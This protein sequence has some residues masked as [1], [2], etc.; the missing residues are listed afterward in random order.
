MSVLVGKNARAKVLTA[1]TGAFASVL[2]CPLMAFGATPEG[3]AAYDKAPVILIVTAAIAVAV[4]L[5]YEGVHRR[6]KRREEDEKEA[7]R[8]ARAARSQDSRARKNN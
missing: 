3:S 4:A 2:C 1:T 5:I 7:A 6:K 8:S